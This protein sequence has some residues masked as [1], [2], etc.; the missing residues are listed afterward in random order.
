MVQAQELCAR[1][2]AAAAAL[3]GEGGG[4][5]GEPVAKMMNQ[6]EKEGKKEIELKLGHGVKGITGRQDSDYYALR[7]SDAEAARRRRSSSE[8]AARPGGIRKDGGGT[9][10]WMRATVAPK[11]GREGVCRAVRVSTA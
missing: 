10:S 3:G 5:G 4:E 9:T 11:S 8:N 6:A 7:L 1:N 2:A